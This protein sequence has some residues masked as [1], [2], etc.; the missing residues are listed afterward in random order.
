MYGAL[1]VGPAMDELAYGQHTSKTGPA[2]VTGASRRRGRED[3]DRLRT[4]T[5]DEN[6]ALLI[7][8]FISKH[9]HRFS[10]IDPP[11]HISGHVHTPNLSPA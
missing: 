7:D 6:H 8:F 2:T 4:R 3:T 1:V 5:S 9:P 11:V 10:F